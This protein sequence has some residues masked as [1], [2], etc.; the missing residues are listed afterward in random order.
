MRGAEG[1]VKLARTL[2]AADTLFILPGHPHRAVDTDAHAPPIR[3]PTVATLTKV[4]RRCGR[5][6]PIDE[7][8][9]MARTADKRHPYC[10]TC[11]RAYNR[12][13][14]EKNRARYIEL[15]TRKK[16]ERLPINRL[17]LRE[18][19]LGHPCVDCGESDPVVLEFD[20]RDP[21]TKTTEVGRTLANYDW[22]RIDKEIEKCV[23]R[24]ANCHRR[25]T[26]RQF[27]WYTVTM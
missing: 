26:A 23:V 20:H 5:G 21:A 25:R 16:R 15:V 14:Y 18:Y 3:P 11:K 8:Q 22:K 10:K 24:C 1:R 13:H 12:A 19:L 4:C 27:G 17:R 2:R 6:Q 7:F 9:R